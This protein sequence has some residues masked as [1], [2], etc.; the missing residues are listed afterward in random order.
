MTQFDSDFHLIDE[1]FDFDPDY[2]FE[3]VWMC[4]CGCENDGNDCCK[5]C[6]REFVDLEEEYA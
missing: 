3:D 1:D 6:G 5:V 2:D 4:T